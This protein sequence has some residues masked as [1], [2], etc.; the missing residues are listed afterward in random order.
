MSFNWEYHR[1]AQNSIGQSYLTNSK[2]P[3]CLGLGAYPTHAKKAHAC[4]IWSD[5]RR[6]VDYIGGLGTNLFGYGHKA[7]A[8]A[9]AEGYMV[10]GNP[11]IATELEVEVAEELKAIIPFIDQVRFLKTGT[12]ACNAAIRMARSYYKKDLVLT[13]GYHGWGDDFVSLTPPADGVP[14]RNYIREYTGEVSDDV[15]AV[16]VEPVE[17]EWGRER[18]EYLKKLRVDTE[19][20]S[21]LIFDEVITGFRW[22]KWSV[23]RDFG[24]TPDVVCLG[25]SIAGGLP[26][27]VVGGKREILSGDYFVSS[28]FA[29]DTVA[30]MACRATI[31]L[32]R[33]GHD[34]DLLWREGQGFIDEFNKLHPEVQIK[35]YP[36]RGVFVGDPLKIELFH[37]ECANAGILFGPSWFYNFPLI[38]ENNRT[39]EVCNDVARKIKLG[40]AKF[41]GERRQS[42]FSAKSRKN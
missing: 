10:G 15:A 5:G 16:I 24:V 12:D 28:T 38:G 11:S 36:T 3:M 42:P 25:K 37:Q 14:A 40:T 21:V 6:Y 29:G 9:V 41:Y 33:T 23:S 31:K 17:T 19:G 4:Y 18:V 27:S 22:K 26:L 32:L 39:L 35:G 20:K 7:I 13:A 2:N 8:E 34:I 1:R 30:L